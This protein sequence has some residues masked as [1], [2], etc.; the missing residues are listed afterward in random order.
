MDFDEL[1]TIRSVTVIDPWT[2]PI[3]PKPKPKPFIYY[4]GMDNKELCHHASQMTDPPHI[5][6]DIIEFYQERHFL[7]IRQRTL[8]IH[9]LLKAAA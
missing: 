9:L 6:T 8:L 7:S 2:P 4:K 3:K 5:V 1:M